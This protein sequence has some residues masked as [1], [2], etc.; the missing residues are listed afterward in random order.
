MFEFYWA[1]ADYGKLMDF[2]EEL[3][4]FVIQEAFGSLQ[5]QRGENTLD[6]SVPFPRVRYA[7]LFKEYLGLD[8]LTISDEDLVAEIKKFRVD[9]DLSLGRGRLLDQLYKKTIRPHLIQPQFVIDIPVELSPLAKRKA[10]DPR[11][12]E[13]ILVLIDGAEIGNGFSEL[14]DPVDQRSR[15]E[16]QERLRLE[17]DAEAQRKDEDFLRALEY[18]M[19][20]T[21]GFGV[22]IDRLVQVLTDVDSIR[23]TVFFPTMR[24]EGGE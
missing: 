16:E 9:T 20:P 12:T 10:D 7:D 18:G 24:P 4:R 3:Y 13:R 19:P 6:F 8:I 15:F 11:L 22:G 14:N 23:E 17:G 2:V 21:A 5:V 1:Y